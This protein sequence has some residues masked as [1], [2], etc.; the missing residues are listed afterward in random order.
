VADTLV[1]AGSVPDFPAPRTGVGLNPLNSRCYPRFVGD[2][3]RR[4]PTTPLMQ[5]LAP[6]EH[7]PP[8]VNQCEANCAETDSRAETGFVR[9]DGQLSTLRA[10]SSDCVGDQRSSTR[11]S[12][13]STSCIRLGGI[14]PTRSVR[15]ILFSVIIAVT[16]TTESRGS[17][18][19]V[20]GKNTLPGIVARAVLEVIT[21][22]STVARRLALYGSDWI[23]STG[24]RFA[25]RLPD[26]GPRSAQ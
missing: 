9:V 6:L 21:A 5:V 16:L 2:P 7:A 22:A 25:G 1:S 12:P 24:R 3:C 8:P 19:A 17:L 15:S 4:S 13:R 18:V 14:S 20:A 10:P 26:G 11:R 23:T